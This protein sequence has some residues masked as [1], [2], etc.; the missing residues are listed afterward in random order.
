MLKK[1]VVMYCATCLPVCVDPA[2]ACLGHPNM[3]QHRPSHGGNVPGA[4]S[5]LKLHNLFKG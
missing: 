3:G 1:F 5:I 4:V 2:A